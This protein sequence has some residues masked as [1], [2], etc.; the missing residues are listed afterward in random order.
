MQLKDHPDDDG[1][2]VWL[3]K[4]ELDTILAVYKGE[5]GSLDDDLEKEY[6]LRLMGECG[7]RTQ[8]MLDVTPDDI[9]T[10]ETD[11]GE[12]TKLRVVNGKNGK[13]R[14]T[15]VPDQLAHDL[16]NYER[17]YAV[18]DGQP[19]VDR[20]RRTIQRWMERAGEH[21][22]SETGNS[23]WEHVT[24]H[25]LRRSWA[26]VLLDNDTAPT[27]VMELGGWENYKTFKEHYLGHHSD[28]TIAREVAGAF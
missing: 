27:V 25:D 15:I 26:M 19:Y 7:L 18:A 8:E 14:E 5:N 3:N 23:D 28:N 22:A 21:V 4:P 11:E 6:A 13:D 2:R 16:R 24:A 10:V 17:A 1:K 9:H 20:S 12:L